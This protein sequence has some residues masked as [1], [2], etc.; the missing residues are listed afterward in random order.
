MNLDFQHLIRCL[1]NLIYY[2]LNFEFI[3]DLE[4][5]FSQI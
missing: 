4:S 2:D 5:N 1:K 3:N